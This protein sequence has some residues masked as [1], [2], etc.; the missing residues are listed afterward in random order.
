MYKL[1]NT[2]LH[3]ALF[4]SLLLCAPAGM[5]G[6]GNGDGSPTAPTTT[7]KTTVTQPQDT[8]V[9]TSGISFGVYYG[10]P[11][12]YRPYRYSYRPYSFYRPYNYSYYY[13]PYR[14]YYYRYY[15]W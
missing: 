12:Y 5:V 6:N 11:S 13:Y 9:S 7:P 4:A 8:G 3:G 14:P 10:R 2:L 1:K 15:G